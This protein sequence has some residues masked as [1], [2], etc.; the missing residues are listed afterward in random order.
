MVS[1]G[2][3]LNVMKTKEIHIPIYG[4]NIFIIYTEDGKKA[5]SFI[6]RKLPKNTDL[7]NTEYILTGNFEKDKNNAMYTYTADENVGF[8]VCGDDSNNVY[9]LSII[10]HECLHLTFKILNHRGVELCHESEEAYTY[11]HQFLFNEV[12]HWLLN[13]K[14]HAK[15]QRKK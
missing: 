8:M 11:L 9:N 3:A 6:K 1:V 7:G 2:Y 12:A 15:K 14:K 13:V 4:E 5:L 10:S